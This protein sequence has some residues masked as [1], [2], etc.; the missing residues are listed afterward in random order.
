VQASFVFA[1]LESNPLVPL[2]HVALQQS[3]FQLLGAQQW[4][5][6]Q[7]RT[8]P[9]VSRLVPLAEPQV[10]LRGSA[11]VDQWRAWLRTS[12]SSL[13]QPITTLPISHGF[14][15]ALD[16]GSEVTVTFAH[17][18]P[19][20]HAFAMMHS[21]VLPSAIG[22]LRVEP[23]SDVSSSLP[24]RSVSFEHLALPEKWRN[25]LIDVVDRMLVHSFDVE[26]AVLVC[27]GSGTGRTSVLQ[28]LQSHFRKQS[29]V[30]VY[31]DGAALVGVPQRAVDDSL[32]RAFASAAVQRPALVLLDD[33]DVL[34]PAVA[35]SAG[36]EPIAAANKRR[37]CW[38]D[39]V[40]SAALQWC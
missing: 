13:P 7:L 33:I 1:V 25:E 38:R 36:G 37:V 34:A 23:A 24:T 12:V 28:A 14:V 21:L 3:L 15:A 22:S 27:G 29:A 8:V 39:C 2:G 30:A 11:T 31:V 5:I 26:P 18:K 19:N 32:R 6:V 9:D 17:S 40:L 10:T 4:S 20:S 16:P 35:Q